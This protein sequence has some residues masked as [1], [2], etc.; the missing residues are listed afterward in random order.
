VSD[1][2]RIS[3]RMLL[4][5][6]LD[7]AD[8]TPRGFR[9]LAGAVTAAIRRGDVPAGSRLPTERSLASALGLSRGSVVAAYELLRDDGLVLRR[10]GS[11]T[12]VRPDV[13][14]IPG[15][16]TA[17]LAAALRAR[18]LTARVIDDGDTAV[19]DLGLS[20]LEEPW[21]LDPSWFDIDMP[22]LLEGGRGHGY[23]PDGVTRLRERFAQDLASRGLAARSAQ[24]ALTHGSQHGIAVATRL[25]VRPGDHVVVE[26]PTFPGAIDAF[27]RAGAR[28]TSIGTDAG[29]A[30]LDELAA[31]LAQGDV[32]VVYTIPTCQSPTGTVMGEARRRALAALIDESSAWSIEDETLAPLC[33]DGPPPPPVASFARSDRHVVV[34][35][36]SKQVWGGL[37]VGWLWADDLVVERL[38][39][40]RAATDLGAPV[41]AQLVALAAV[42]G[43]EGRTSELRAELRRRCDLLCDL[44]QRDLPDWTVTRPDGG[45]SVWCR[46]PVEAGDAL[47]TVAPQLG[48]AVLAGSSATA[49]DRGADHVRLSFAARPARLEAGVERL[50]EAWRV[51]ND[52]VSPQRSAP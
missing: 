15:E 9:P 24:V 7:G 6:I 1:D 31:V 30:R 41:H 4:S 26:S 5:M 51:T 34:G 29:G 38:V 3:A 10:Q 25:L 50:V 35:S 13:G 17:E 16:P 19:I 48:V 14:P 49:D 33:F 23:L 44:L 21:Q 45:L 28:L 27:A 8:A 43:L 37:R 32:R 46:L 39:R 36:L 22:T 18:R 42:E 11:G 52:A 40:L 12:W 47:A 2:V 20:A